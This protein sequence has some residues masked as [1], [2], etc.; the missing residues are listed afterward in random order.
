MRDRSSVI[1]IENEKLALIKR[2]KD[3]AEYYVFPGGGIKDGETKKEAAEREAW[4]ELGVKVKVGK[5]FSEVAF[6]G[7]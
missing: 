3:D 1:I 6:N 4:E 5:Y 2:T 7:V